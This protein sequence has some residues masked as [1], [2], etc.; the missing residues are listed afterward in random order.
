MI[1][2]DSDR[3]HHVNAAYHGGV[4]KVHV[5]KLFMAFHTAQTAAMTNTCLVLWCQ[6]FESVS[7]IGLVKAAF[8]VLE[9]LWIFWQ[10]WWIAFFCLVV[11][12]F[13]NQIHLFE[14]DACRFLWTH[15]CV[16]PKTKASCHILK[17]LV[18]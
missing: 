11:S 16:E 14:L 4:W 8:T 6:A 15:S 12:H 3:W 13:S 1:A 9:L 10:I 18:F 7:S 5:N 17:A 2:N